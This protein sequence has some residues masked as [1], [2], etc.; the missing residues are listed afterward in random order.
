MNQSSPNYSLSMDKKRMLRGSIFLTLSPVA[1]FFLGLIISILIDDLIPASDYAIFS[2]FTLMNSFLITLIPFRIPGA[3]SRYLAV[4]KGA[5]NKEDTQTLLKTNTL[6]TLLLVPLSGVVTLVIT[7]FILNHPLINIGGQ[8][9]LLDLVIFTLGIMSLNLANFTVSALKGMQ[10]FNKIGIAQFFANTIGQAA[11]IFLLVYGVSIQGITALGIQALLMKWVIVGLLTSVILIISVRQIWTLRGMQPSLKPLLRYAY[12]MVISFLFTFL[13][14][15]FLVRYFLN[16]V[17]DELGLYGFAVR[18]VAF[19]NALTIG[20]YTAL[21]AYYAHSYGKGNTISLENDVRWTLKISL[22]LFL[23]LI[24]GVMVIAPSFFVLVLPNYYWAYQYFIILLAQVLLMIFNKPFALVL[25]ALAKTRTVL[26]IQI[27][28]SMVSGLLMV[29]FFIYGP[30]FVFWGLI[31]NALLL[32]VLGY[33]SRTFFALLL[34]TFIVRR[35][36]GIRKGILQ[37]IPLV[38]IGLCIIPPAVL[39]HLL[40]LPPVFE[41]YLI[42]LVSVLIYLLPIRFFRLIS[43]VE[44]RKASQ[45]L[46]KRLADPF[47]R[48][49]IRLF[50]RHSQAS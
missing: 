38:L 11:V 32:V 29:L 31:D 30:L 19:V 15:E 20:F 17:G 16:A 12:P 47:A 25:N 13:F 28:S 42:V 43:E 10:E 49:I 8:Y 35:Y 6:L 27:I 2:W 48:V 44:I 22:F 23:P 34:S 37:V 3:I 46:P 45:F 39:I 21:D 50:V 1:A 7:P 33:A 14:S 18:I 4:S 41:F 5:N 26:I 9:S 40:Y 24:L 36:I